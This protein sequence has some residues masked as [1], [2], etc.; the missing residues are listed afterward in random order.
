MSSHHQK[1]T[2]AAQKN[3]DGSHKILAHQEIEISILKP[4]E[5]AKYNEIDPNFGREYLKNQ[6]DI[7][8]ELVNDGKRTQSNVNKAVWISGFV[9]LSFFGCIFWLLYKEQFQN[10]TI[11]LGSGIFST[12]FAFLGKSL[13]NPYRKK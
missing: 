8:R 5:L 10:A 11:L 6:I 3:K 1:N 12:I 2:I 9:V 7:P 13:M 4:E